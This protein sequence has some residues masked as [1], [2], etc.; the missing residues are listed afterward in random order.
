MVRLKENWDIE[1]SFAFTFQFLMV[2]LKVCQPYSYMFNYIKF[3]FLMVRLK[4][5]AMKLEYMQ[6]TTFQFLMVRLKVSNV[7]FEHID[8]LWISIPYGAIK[9]RRHRLLKMA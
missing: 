5:K 9:S 6:T 3:Q 4:G 8:L 7:A 1:D 2:R